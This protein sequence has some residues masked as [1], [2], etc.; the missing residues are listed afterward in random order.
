MDWI[1]RILNSFL[2]IWKTN[3]DLEDNYHLIL[4]IMQNTL[5]DNYNHRLIERNNFP[6]FTSYGAWKIYSNNVHIAN[7]KYSDY[8]SW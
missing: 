5:R 8:D 2:S 3:K 1:L 6:V 4:Y 7:S